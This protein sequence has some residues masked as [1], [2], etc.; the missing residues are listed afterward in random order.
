M[1]LC[2]LSI[3]IAISGCFSRF[4]S[5]LLPKEFLS[6]ADGLHLR[7]TGDLDGLDYKIFSLVVVLHPDMASHKTM[8]RTGGYAVVVLGSYGEPANAL[9]GI[10]AAQTTVG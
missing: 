6:A 9:S 7:L 4:L 1:I 3:C 8:H 10:S 2:V 5:P